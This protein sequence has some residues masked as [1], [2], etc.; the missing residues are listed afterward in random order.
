MVPEP[1]SRRCH[2][3]EKGRRRPRGRSCTREARR[4][5]WGRV[6]RLAP[7]C[8]GCPARRLQWWSGG[9]GPRGSCRR[10][11]CR[12]WTVGR[13]NGFCRLHRE[14]H[15]GRGCCCSLARLFSFALCFSGLWDDAFRH[16]ELIGE[17][18]Q[19]GNDLRL[20]A[21]LCLAL[22]FGSAHLFGLRNTD[23]QRLH[24]DCGGAVRLTFLWAAAASSCAFLRAAAWAA[25]A[26]SASSS[27]SMA[28]RA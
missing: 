14:W 6:P 3:R 24:S 4:G 18:G 25:A 5:Y 1:Y 9:R 22:L 19:R 10:G 7:G 17:E 21:L 20:A 2:L 27:R 28:W 16:S 11:R 8:K 15:P 26:S 13:E 23:R 12:R